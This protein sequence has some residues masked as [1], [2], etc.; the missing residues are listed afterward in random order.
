MTTMRCLVATIL[1]ALSL[2][3]PLVGQTMG[4]IV[5][6]VKDT[7]EAIIP[8][9]QVTVTNV[10]TNAARVATT[11]AAGLYS[12]PSLVP[13]VYRVRVEAKGFKTVTKTDIELQV[14]QTARVD[15]SMEVGQVT[16]SIEVSANAVMMAT[17]NATVGTVIE[18]KRIV[19]LPLN[20]RNF[21]QLVSLSPNVTYGFATPGQV[22]GRQGGDRGNQN[23]SLM[24]MRGTWNRFSLDGIEDT[25]VNFN[26][27][28]V[29]PSI[30]ALQEFKVQ[31]GIYPAEFGRAAS[32]INV[33]TKAGTNEY[34]GALFE[35]MR[36]D[37]LD[38]KP[39][40][41]VGSK[42][43]KQPFKYNQFGFTLGGPIQIPKVFNGKDKL[44]FMTNYE[45]FRQRTAGYGL[46]TTPTTAMRNGDFSYALASGNQLYDPA[47]KQFVNGSLTGTPFS[48]NQ[49]P[50]TRFDPIS[51]KLLEF[52]PAPNLTTTALSNNYQVAQPGVVDKN[53][54]TVRGDFNESSSSQW[55]GRYSWTEEASLSKGWAQNGTTLYTKA[56]QAMIS[57]TRVFGGNKVNEFRFGVNYFYNL[58]GLELSG[59]RDVVGEL[60]IPGLR[61]PDPI[62]WGIPRITNVVG[63][64]GF[65]ND[66]S[67]PF[68]IN[69]A[70]FQWTDNFSLIKGKHSLRF[71]GEIRRDRYNQKGNEFARGSF[72]FN[73]QYTSNPFTKKGGDSTADLLLGT[74]NRGE[75]ALWLAFAQF[76][77]TSAYLYIDDTYRLSPKLTINAGLRYELSPPYWDRSQNEVSVDVPHIIQAINVQDKSLHPVFVRTGSGDF[78]EGKG[79]RYPGVPVARDGRLG[80]RLVR[81]D[82]TNWAPRLGVAYSPTAKWTFRTGFGLFYSVESGN[83]RFDLNRG[84][85]ARVARDADPNV[86]NINFNNFLTGAADPWILPAAP[87]LWSAEY[88]LWNTYS[89]MYL[90]N[91]Q[92]QLNRDTILEVG[93]NGSA[94]RHLQGLQ[95]PNAPLPGTVGNQ[96]SRRPFPEY[97]TI[98]MIHAG[99][100]GNYNGLGVKLTRRM[101]AGLTYLASYTWSKSLDT[102]SAIRGTNVDIFPQDSY[103]LACEYGYSAF[104]TPH[105][106]VTSV[107]YELPFGKGKPLADMGGVV[108]QIVGG[109]QVGSI[110]TWQ[111]GRPL[112]MQAGYD[113]SG[114]YKY[115][116]VRQS[117]TGLDPYATDQSAN[118]WFNKKALTLPSPGTYGNI[119]RN[120]LI[121]PTTLT[122]DFSTLKNFPIREGTYVQ[123]RF[124]AFN[125]PNHPRLGDPNLSWGSRDAA[126]PGP[127]FG[128]IR[129]TQSMRQ[130]QMGMKLVF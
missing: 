112:N 87:Y 94:S 89:M 85:A 95:D 76:R 58:L 115:G 69:D 40:D 62:T 96:T 12:F 67:G 22:S 74:M 13:G 47:S 50:K 27:Y 21:L 39:Y 57:N 111:S 114:T 7:T 55:F 20:G 61:T 93:Y 124:E 106:F 41:F 18:N 11:N 117:A 23:I 100:T 121:G 108:N 46:Y 73:G 24:G 52:W 53:Q 32:Q 19:E 37:K 16:E 122:W 59:V 5:G 119:S 86:T 44:F 8:G 71:G 28:V 116:E 103:C 68:A 30:D 36:N 2:G 10:G 88:N 26:L 129:S 109:W 92:R 118:G 110:I 91:V 3:L 128:L 90:L 49:I 1:F 4:E 104:N 84:L 63:V 29:L 15:I 17:E 38:A 31:S 127:N 72:E 130:L 77:A 25:D 80:D 42:P 54:F 82:T 70:L 34:H 43:T 75:A 33:S 126:A 9:A 35:F 125:F 83:S 60:G 64:S 99:G 113:V 66:S 56:W 45:G 107:M 105:R 98:Q 97:G 14:Q 102:A 65:G 48:G 101:S 6:E 51:L 78:Y 81:T 120:R 79:F 123:F